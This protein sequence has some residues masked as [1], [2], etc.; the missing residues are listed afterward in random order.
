MQPTSYDWLR[1]CAG[2]NFVLFS[3]TWHFYVQL[4]S[5]FLSLCFVLSNKSF[6]FVLQCSIAYCPHRKQK[7]LDI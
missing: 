2:R 4:V 7:D 1:I 6:V 3:A 5:G